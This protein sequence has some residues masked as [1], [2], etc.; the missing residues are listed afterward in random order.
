[1]AEEFSQVNVNLT[2]DD[3]QKLERIAQMLTL[4]NR[5]ACVRWIIR[6]QYESIFGAIVKQ[7]EQSQ[8]EQG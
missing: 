2:Q 6:R 7:N 1:M 8:P 5:S 4:D 3:V